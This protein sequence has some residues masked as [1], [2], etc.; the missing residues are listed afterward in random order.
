MNKVTCAD[1]GLEYNEDHLDFCSKCGS[2]KIKTVSLLPSFN[3]PKPPVVVEPEPSITEE[4]L[5]AFD[6]TKGLNL[7]IIDPEDVD[8][9]MMMIM[10]G[11]KENAFG[12]CTER[13]RVVGREGD[14]LI[15]EPYDEKGSIEARKEIAKFIVQINEKQIK[16][17]AVAMVEKALTRKPIKKLERIAKESKKKGILSKLKTSTGCVFLVVGNEEVLL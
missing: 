12:I 4:M 1:C 3:K 16:E 8:K 7:K 17:S 14:K 5:D 6:P 2:N 15:L 9:D 11:K 13:F 10:L